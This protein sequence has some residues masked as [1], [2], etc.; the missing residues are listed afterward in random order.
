MSGAQVV[1]RKWEQLQC[2]YVRDLNRL[3]PGPMLYRGIECLGG[4]KHRRSRLRPGSA[5]T[6][7]RNPRNITMAYDDME[8]PGLYCPLAASTWAISSRRGRIF[9]AFS[10]AW[11]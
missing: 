10:L 11:A 8:S 6:A 4:V 9:S 1:H 7:T 5:L 3:A 2:L